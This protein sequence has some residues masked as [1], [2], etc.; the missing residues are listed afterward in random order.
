MQGRATQLWGSPCLHGAGFWVGE[1]HLGHGR[2]SNGGLDPLGAAEGAA[3][4]SLGVQGV[5]S[6]LGAILTHWGDP[7]LLTQEQGCSGEQQELC[8]APGEGGS[9]PWGHDEQTQRDTGQDQEERT[10][11]GGGGRRGGGREGTRLMAGGLWKKRPTQSGHA[12][13]TRLS[14]AS[15]A[16]W[17]GAEGGSLSRSEAVPILLCTPFPETPTILIISACISAAKPTMN[18]A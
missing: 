7:S 10:A 8:G 3:T 18:T 16:P 4:K 12:R 17:V 2:A 14:P 15:P 11:A 9:G 13:P 1:G 5:R 6:L